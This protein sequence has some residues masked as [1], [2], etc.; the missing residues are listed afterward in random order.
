[1]TLEE[2]ELYG[3]P[4]DK[5]PEWLIMARNQEYGSTYGCTTHV[6]ELLDDSSEHRVFPYKPVS[7]PETCCYI[8]PKG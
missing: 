2:I 5:K 6:G 3:K 7:G 8:Y 1:M 4:C